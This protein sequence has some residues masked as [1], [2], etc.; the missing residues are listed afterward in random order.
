[1]SIKEIQAKSILRK[2]KKIDSWFI[3][4]YGM[5]LYRGCSHN[6]TYC[7]GR[8]EKYNVEGE[9]GEDVSVKVNAVEILKKEL[10]PTGKRKPFKKGY[11]L[12]GGGVGDA[13]Q[14]AEKKYLLARN[15]LLLLKEYSRPVHIL[16]KSTLIRRDL[17]LIEEINRKSRAIVS[18]SFSNVNKTVSSIFE[19]GVPSPEERLETISFFRDRG[20]ACGMFLLPVI[21]FVSDTEEF[22]VDS[23][24][25][26]KNAGVSFIIFGGLTLKT[27]RQKDYFLNIIK[28]YNP[29][30]LK[31]YQGL[32]TSDKWGQPAGRYFSAINRRFREIVRKYDIP[33][34]IPPELF[35]DI[36][37][38]NDLVTVMLEQID[39]IL[40]LR[41][42]SS[43]YGYAAYSIS[44]LKE[45]LSHIHSDL[46]KIPGVGKFTEKIILEILNAGSSSYYRK[47]MRSI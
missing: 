13:Y 44:Q 24:R 10:D 8:T 33:V 31:E 38:E 1:M 45:P 23:V 43:P 21:P 9:F 30:L 28:K 41:G 26:A 40:K 25:R 37:S 19:P 5:N 47:L 4:W 36:L 42:E 29:G 27:G 15:A 14:P 3:S 32:Y 46:I 2:A 12:L 11:V 20:I 22:I 39:Y 18:F 17:N 16:T 7:D 6:C 34:R 35:R